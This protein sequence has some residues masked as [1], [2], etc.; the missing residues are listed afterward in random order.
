[1]NSKLL[2][3]CSSYKL[4]S[5]ELQHDFLE[6]TLIFCS[7]LSSHIVPRI[8]S[9]SL[10]RTG[11]AMNFS[12]INS[13]VQSCQSKNDISRIVNATLVRKSCTTKICLNDPQKAEDGYEP[14]MGHQIS[15]SKAHNRLAIK[16]SCL[17]QLTLLEKVTMINI[18]LI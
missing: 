16:V 13:A 5:T 1:M 10:T 4:F 15:I 12:I 17:E 18:M 6:F 14:N 7:H 11:K 9:S 8:I 3:F 2:D